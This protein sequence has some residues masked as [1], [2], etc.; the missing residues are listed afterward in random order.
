M[1]LLSISSIVL[2]LSFLSFFGI[3]FILDMV[4]IDTF[5]RDNLNAFSFNMLVVSILDLV[6][7]LALFI[8]TMPLPDMLKRGYANVAFFLHIDY[9][10]SSSTLSPLYSS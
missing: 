4:S 5:I 2:F 10:K 8:M 3:H 9:R 1:D 7:F 6:V